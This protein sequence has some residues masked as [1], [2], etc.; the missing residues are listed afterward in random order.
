M[1]VVCGEGPDVASSCY[2][3][4]LKLQDLKSQIFSINM[5]Y[6][7]LV[8]FWFKKKKSII[9]EGRNSQTEFS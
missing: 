3:V 2:H 9:L 8:R 5:K 6:E 1:S 4:F 7:T